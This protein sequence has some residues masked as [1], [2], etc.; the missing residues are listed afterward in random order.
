MKVELLM[1]NPHSKTSAPLLSTTP[2][3][4]INYSQLQSQLRSQVKLGKSSCQIRNNGHI[5]F[6]LM[7]IKLTDFKD[8]ISLPLA[9]EPEVVVVNLYLGN[10][11]CYSESIPC[12]YSCMYDFYQKKVKTGLQTYSP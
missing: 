1:D 3:Q 8:M 9:T 7:L 4:F 5:G 12:G 10:W 6:F 2:S 11:S